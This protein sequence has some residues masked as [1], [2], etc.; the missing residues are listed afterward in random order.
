MPTFLILLQLMG[1]DIYK[2]RELTYIFINGFFLGKF[3]VKW[4]IF[5]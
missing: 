4:E 2:I 5:K 3:K 1:Y